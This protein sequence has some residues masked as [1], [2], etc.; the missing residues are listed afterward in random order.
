MTKYHVLAIFSKSKPQSIDQKIIATMNTTEANAFI[1]V[2]GSQ[3]FSISI[4][5]IT[6]FTT[7]QAQ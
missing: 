6:F 3:V 2:S 1:F 4:D 5:I 7:D